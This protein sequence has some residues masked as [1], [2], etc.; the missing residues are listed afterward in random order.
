MLAKFRVQA[1]KEEKQS[2]HVFIRLLTDFANE[3]DVVWLRIFGF[4]SLGYKGSS[5][6]GACHMLGCSIGEKLSI[7]LPF[8]TCLEK[9]AVRQRQIEI[10]VTSQR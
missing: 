2:G 10:R 8:F 7:P 3:Q 5:P 1:W 6:P 4:A 9:E